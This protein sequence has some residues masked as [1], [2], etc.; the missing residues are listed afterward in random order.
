MSETVDGY[1]NGSEITMTEFKTNILAHKKI[2]SNPAGGNCLFHSLSYL[3][4]KQFPEKVDSITN[5]SIRKDICNYYKKTFRSRKTVNPESEALAALSRGSEIEKQLF[6]LYTFGSV[7][8]ETGNYVLEA[9]N[10]DHQLEVCNKTVWGEEVD[11]VVACI[12]YNI[13]IVV[14]SLL[15]P[16]NYSKQP[17]YRVL[18]YKNSNDVPT[19][20]LHMK[21]DGV[22]SHYEAM[23]DKISSS[24]RQ[25][26]SAKKTEKVKE[27][28]KEKSK[29]KLSSEKRTTRKGKYQSVLDKLNT[30]YAKIEQFIPS[31]NKQHIADEFSDIQFDV[32][33]I[34]SELESIRSISSQ[35]LSK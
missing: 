24:L 3:M 21:M 12:I 10:I 25:I 34:I 6:K 11:I 29:E 1:V 35:K 17:I 33:T 30:F 18:T 7:P 23:Y 22:S 9:H 27:K 5:R 4:K 14:F 20:Y 26:P 8:D 19:C 32:V 31:S 28:L 15:P 13:N 16:S 2:V